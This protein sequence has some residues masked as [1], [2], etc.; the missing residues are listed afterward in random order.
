[1]IPTAVVVVG[2][3]TAAGVIGLMGTGAAT[4]RGRAHTGHRLLPAG[5]PYAAEVYAKI[6]GSVSVVRTEDS[7]TYRV[8]QGDPSNAHYSGSFNLTWATTY[9]QVTVPVADQRELGAAA[10]RLHVDVQPTSNG[11]GGLLDSSYSIEGFGPPTVGSTQPS[12]C[13]KKS[14]SQDGSFKAQG[15]PT[16]GRTDVRKLFNDPQHV[17]FFA[18]PMV[19]ATP[20]QYFDSQGT[21]IQVDE[22]RSDATGA[23]PQPQNVIVTRPAWDAVFGDFGINTLKQLVHKGQIVV[24]PKYAGD[25]DCGSHSS[26]AGVYTCKVKWSYVWEVK[27]VRRFLY[28]TR[29]AYRR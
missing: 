28:R 15:R 11:T 17:F 5:T 27:L 19:R 2:T 18:M 16:F 8:C 29:R 1:M 9:P 21:P 7:T 14:Y 23:V 20:A 22:D 25:A 13:A 26:D 6:T 3:V 10:M 12:D 24:H 4:A